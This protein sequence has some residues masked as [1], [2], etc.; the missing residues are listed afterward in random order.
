MEKGIK[1]W[2]Q[3]HLP[4]ANSPLVRCPRK[5]PPVNFSLMYSPNFSKAPWYV[6]N[7]CVNAFFAW[8]SFF[9]VLWLQKT[10]L[11]TALNLAKISPLLQRQ[12]IDFF[13]WKPKQHIWI[14]TCQDTISKAKSKSLKNLW[15]N[16]EFHFC[17]FFGVEFILF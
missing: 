4:R 8:F 7:Q 16:N 6:P 2:Y 1:K 15:K 12:D 11:R 3:E 13:F 10:A 9:L 14:I 17:S 5:N